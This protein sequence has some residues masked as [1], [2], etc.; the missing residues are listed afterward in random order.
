MTLGHYIPLQ[1]GF[2]LS[3]EHYQQRLIRYPG[4][5]VLYYQFTAPLSDLPIQAVPDGCADILF[6]CTDMNPQAWLR[7]SAL[8]WT[9]VFNQPGQTYFGI[10]LSPSVSRRLPFVP[11]QQVTGC[12]VDLVDICSDAEQWIDH[13]TQCPHFSD[14]VSW[15]EQWLIQNGVMDGGQTDMIGHSLERIH[16]TCGVIRIEELANEVH[17][18]A[19][20]LRHKFNTEM[21]LSPKKYARI[22]RFQATLEHLVSGTESEWMDPGQ[23]PS[24]ASLDDDYGYYDQS[25]FYKEFQEFTNCTP[26]QLQFQLATSSSHHRPRSYSAIAHHGA[27]SVA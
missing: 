14:R 26:K 23:S 4:L 7:G 10:R 15:S 12:K 8:R 24:F 6:C 25:H 11:Y 2:K 19:R 22:V 20:S 5:S 21:G 9:P 27:T 13:L 1:Y 3:G 16:Q 18:S 17:C